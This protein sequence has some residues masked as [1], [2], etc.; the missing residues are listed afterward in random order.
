VSVIGSREQLC[1]HE[2]VRK[3]TSNANK[4][5]QMRQQKD[6]VRIVLKKKTSVTKYEILP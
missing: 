6:R 3:E 4:V 2:H 1:I 5:R